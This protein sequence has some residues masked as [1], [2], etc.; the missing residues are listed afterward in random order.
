[1]KRK[2]ILQVLKRIKIRMAFTLTP[3]FWLICLKVEAQPLTLIKV[4]GVAQK[5]KYTISYLSANGTNYSRQVDSLLK[6]INYTFSRYDTG[7][8]LSYINKHNHI[9]ISNPHFITVFNKAEEVSRNTFG[10]FDI[11]VSALIDYWGF[12]KNR[13]NFIDSLQVDSVL[14]YVG[15]QKVKLTN[16]RL[17]KMY[18]NSTLD[19][20]AIAQGYTSDLIASFLESKHITNYLIDVGGEL[21][22]RGHNAQGKKWKIGINKPI[23][24]TT[25]TIN[26][27]QKI[28][29]VGDAGIATSGSYRKVRYYKE[30]KLGHIFDPRT[31]YPSNTSIISITLIAKD[32]ITADAYATACMVL[33]LDK[34]LELIENLKMAAFIIYEDEHA[35]LQTLETKRFK[36]FVKMD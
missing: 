12:Y 5:S 3:L 17:E 11:T 31:G 7:S 22:C 19:F 28:I 24:D 1:M 33:G 14:A 4:E 20:N 35:Q 18:D 9:Y 8:Y 16:G 23:V 2:L 32:C 27:I 15:Y 6:E 10:S 25:H 36:R 26:E 34:S 30:R 29:A 21:R 13:I